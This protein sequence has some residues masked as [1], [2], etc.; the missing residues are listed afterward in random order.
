VPG[1]RGR[2]GKALTAADLKPEAL[3]KQIKRLEGEMFKKA[4]NLEFEDAARLRDEIER[5]K[6]LELG[7]PAPLTQ[8]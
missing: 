8:T 5:L 6:Q 1:E 2:R 4:R 7:F 3:V